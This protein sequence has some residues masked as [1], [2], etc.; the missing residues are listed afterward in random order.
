MKDNL[1]LGLVL[2]LIAPILVFIFLYYLKFSYYSF[3]EFWD[4]FSKESRLVTFFGAWC[5]V[6]NIALFTLY[7]N[8]HRDRTAKGVF[9]VTLV[10]GIAVLLMKL[11]M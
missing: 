7:I 2:G 9:A 6:G 10:Y 4:T 1:Q 11:W 5:L 3:P 8:T